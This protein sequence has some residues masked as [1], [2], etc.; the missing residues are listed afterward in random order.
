MR[1]ALR[2]VIFLNIIKFSIWSRSD[3]RTT[4]DNLV[5]QSQKTFWMYRPFEQV[6]FTNI[7]LL[8]SFAKHN[9]TGKCTFSFKYFEKFVLLRISLSFQCLILSSRTTLSF[10]TWFKLTI[11]DSIFFS[12]LIKSGSYS[13]IDF[14]MDC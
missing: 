13:L 5:P 6:D 9:S 2:E 11:S 8:I 12:L 14:H 1:I 3:S 4:H 7:Y 10:C